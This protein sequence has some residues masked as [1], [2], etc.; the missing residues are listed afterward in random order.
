MADENIATDPSHDSTNPEWQVVIVKHGTRT[1][2]RSEAFLNYAFYEEPDGP[3]RIDYYFWVLRRGDQVVIVDTGFSKFE[4]F[5][6]SRSILVDPIDALRMLDI[7]PESAHPVIITHA[8]YDHIGNVNAFA[9]SEI[10]LSSDEWEFW[11]SEMADRTLFAH[12]GDRSAM[13]DLVRIGEQSRLRLFNGPHTVAPGVEVI[14]L[15]GHTPGQAIVKVATTAGMVVLASDAMHFHEE[16]DR[17][18]LFQSMTDLPAS[19]RT[20]EI[21][22]AMDSSIIVSGH[23]AGE[24]ARHTAIT[25]PLADLAATIGEPC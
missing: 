1:T 6:R 16:L 13:R 19:Y 11:T 24:L 10:Y 20:L 7:D 22:R 18:M 12:F 2:T 8:H 9:H 17:D 5:S 4:A 15:G 21:L 3:Y 23:D 14:P 25:G